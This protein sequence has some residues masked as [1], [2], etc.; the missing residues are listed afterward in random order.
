MRRP[1]AMTLALLFS[2]LLGAPALA[3]FGPQ[4]PPAVGVVQAV[5]K[6]MVEATEFIGRVEAQYRVDLRARVTGFLQERLF[7]EGQEVKA[8]ELLFRI[9]PAPFEAQLEQARAGLAS[10]QA[11]LVNAQVSLVRARTL[12]STGTGSQAALDTAQAQERTAAAAVLNAQAQVRIAEINLGYTGVVAPVAGRIGRATYA[13]GN[14][15]G[16]NADVLATLVSQDPMRISFTVNQRQLQEL[17]NRYDARGGL[18]AAMVVRVR[19][20]DGRAY[21]QEGRI[22]FIDPL[23]DRNMD[24]MLVRALIPNPVRPGA[25]PGSQGDRELVDGQFVSV[26]AEGAEPV[27]ALVI[28]RAAVLQD[29]G[30]AFC[31]IVGEG[32]KAERRNLVLG[33]STAAEAVVERGLEGGETVITEGMQRVQPGGVVN[34][35][36][37][38][39]PAP[40]RPGPASRPAG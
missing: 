24:T 26:S 3:Q 16:P 13:I 28:P 35:A 12:R 27:Q 33:R 34:P 32:N 21:A 18:A 4:G 36:P 40:P 14:V 6:P 10:A 19:L 31:F 17:R 20:S 7:A 38:G 11:L 8:G 15:V 9:E 1:A 29:Q 22:E 25:A 5:R 39:S 2:T 23:V 30:G 37:A